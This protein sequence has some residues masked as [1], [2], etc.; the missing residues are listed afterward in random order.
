MNVK[1]SLVTVCFSRY[2]VPVPSQ[3]T[4][5]NP[6]SFIF[7]SGKKKILVNHKEKESQ[8]RYLRNL[9]RKNPVWTAKYT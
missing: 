9:E 6:N 8:S 7:K 3:P 2:K 4:D 5:F 1:K